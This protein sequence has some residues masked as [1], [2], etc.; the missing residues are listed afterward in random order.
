MEILAR[1]R[2]KRGTTVAELNVLYATAL[3][4][5]HLSNVEDDPALKAASDPKVRRFCP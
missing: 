3:Q 1:D 2:R 5:Q 4:R